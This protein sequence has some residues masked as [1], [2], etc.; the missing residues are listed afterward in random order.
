MSPLTKKIIN[1]GILAL[2]LAIAALLSSRF[3]PE[4]IDRQSSA[5]MLVSM[6]IISS[7]VFI[8]VHAGDNKDSDVQT[9]FSLAS[10]GLKFILSAVLAIVYFKGFKKYGMNNILLFFVLYLTFAVYTVTVVVN[11]LKTRSLKNDQN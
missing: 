3:Y 10:I 1:T 9:M 2:I 4:L 8:L 11:T 7:G 6:F 5:I